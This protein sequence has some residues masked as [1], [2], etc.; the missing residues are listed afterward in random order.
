MTTTCFRCGFGLEVP[1]KEW[2]HFITD[3]FTHKHLPICHLCYN[4]L[5]DEKPS[6]EEV[7]LRVSP[8]NGSAQDRAPKLAD[9][10][11]SLKGTPQDEGVLDSTHE[12]KEEASK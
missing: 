9:D 5:T 12:P 8:Q 3:T 4:Q 1:K 7:T 11:A 6:E 2:R 10:R